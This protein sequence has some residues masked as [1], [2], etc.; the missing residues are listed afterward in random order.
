MKKKVTACTEVSNLKN[1]PAATACLSKYIPPEKSF[2]TQMKEIALNN[3]VLKVCT[4]TKWIY[5][6][7]DMLYPDANFYIYPGCEKETVIKDVVMQRYFLDVLKVHFNMP[8]QQD[9]IF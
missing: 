2:E 4:M 5:K 9:R 8:M 3:L 7:M 1:P 6:K